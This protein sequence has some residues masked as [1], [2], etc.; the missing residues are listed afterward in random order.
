VSW[1]PLLY[2]LFSLSNRPGS[3]NGSSSSWRV[4]ASAASSN[5]S[6]K[7]S[8]PLCKSRIIRRGPLPRSS[9]AIS[10]AANSLLSRIVISLMSSCFP[11]WLATPSC[12]PAESQWTRQQSP[13]AG[14]Q[15]LWVRRRLSFMCSESALPENRTCSRFRQIAR[16]Q[17]GQS[18]FPRLQTNA[19]VRVE[20]GLA[21]WLRLFK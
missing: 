12:E 18:L 4:H 7:I 16:S 20:A 1:P 6:R 2:V 13:R 11:R 3:S 14:P 8:C 19:R 5:G 21:S 17:G 15:R 10:T 9:R